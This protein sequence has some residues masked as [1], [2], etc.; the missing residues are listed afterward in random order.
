[1]LPTLTEAINVEMIRDGGS[2]AA[3]FG[4]KDGGRYILFTRIKNIDRDETTRERIGYEP[5]ILIDCDPTKRPPDTDKVVYSELGG[6]AI[7]ITWAE[8]RTI[9]A[10]AEGLA[11]GLDEWRRKWLDQMNHVVTS[12]GGLPPD[13]DA[14]VQVRRPPSTAHKS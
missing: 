3:T 14:I 2:Y 8:A 6:P 13:V 10:L 5:P 9:M 1:M 7:A 11:K 4:D 12:D